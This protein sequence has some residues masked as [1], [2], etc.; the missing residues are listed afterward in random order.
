M[1]IC[2]LAS[3][4]SG[5]CT[6]VATDNT[7]ILVDAGLSRAETFRRLTLIG[8][9]PENL[10][11]ILITHE[12][13]DH[14]GGLIQIAAKLNLPVYLNKGTGAAI[15]WVNYSPRSIVFHGPFRIK[16]IEITPLAIPHDAADPV[17]FEFCNGKTAAVVTDLGHIPPDLANRLRKADFLL[18]ESNHDTDM[19]AAGPHPWKVKQRVM[20]PLGH[21]SNDA[22][23]TFIKEGVNGRVILGHLSESNNN[24][25]LV[26]ALT[27]CDVLPCGSMSKRYTV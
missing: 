5:N 24:P 19:L 15:P 6:F 11:A 1:T 17:G 8:E 16:D 23:A 21:L 22:V 9:R 10:D 4:S 18:L 12:H 25:D 26:A 7:R 3:G 20:G 13:V 2:A 14:I 27:E